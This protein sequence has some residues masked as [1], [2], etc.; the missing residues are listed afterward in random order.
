AQDI[1]FSRG[2]MELDHSDIDPHE[3]RAGV[4]E[5]IAREPEAGDVVVGRQMLVGDAHVDV[6]EVDDIA[7]VLGCAIVFFFGHGSF[8]ERRNGRGEACLAPT[9]ARG[10]LEWQYPA[11]SLPRY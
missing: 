4:E 5:R 8:S 1:R 7:E 9:M 3:P 6:P 2:Q 10:P 11:Q